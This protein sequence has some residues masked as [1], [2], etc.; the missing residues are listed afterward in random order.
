VA[1]Q[2]VWGP[3]WEAYIQKLQ[4]QVATSVG[5]FPPQ[6]LSQVLWA[7]AKLRKQP[8]AE[9]LRLLLQ[10]FLQQAVLGNAKSQ[11]V[12]NVVW[13]LGELCRLPD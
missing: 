7:C 13:A 11:A 10:A 1:V 5:S 2:R 4:Q 3:T 6:Q 12:A 9:E 8:A